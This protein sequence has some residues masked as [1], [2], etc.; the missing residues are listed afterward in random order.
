MPNQF[1]R[2]RLKK[3]YNFSGKDYGKL[4]ERIA[5]EN[6]EKIGAAVA[7]SD[8]KKL[9]RNIKD[10]EPKGKRGKK[11]KLPD[12]S[13]IIRR[14]P[15]ILKAAENGRLLTKTLREK[16]RKAVKEVMLEEGI[17]TTRGTVPKS[18]SAKVEKR[19][20]ETFKEYAERNP[21]YGMPTNVHTIAVTEAR[22]AANGIRREYMDAV[23]QETDRQL[24]KRWK[25]NADMSKHPR[26]NHRAMDGKEV[27]A[28]RKF[29]LKGAD[30]RTY[31]TDGPHAPELPIG[32]KAGCNCEESFRFAE[33]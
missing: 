20:Q 30:G 4:M 12:V 25:H 28:G 18:L 19:F 10:L 31:L 33:K 17:S 7:N 15:T 1:E 22:S 13:S 23:A 5:R 11:I 24:L 29:K 2:A 3:K 6:A 8:R 16:M 26:G 14:S 27:K 32:E 9:Q 21:K